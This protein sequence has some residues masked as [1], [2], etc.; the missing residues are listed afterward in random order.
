MNRPARP[1]SGRPAGSAAARTVSISEWQAYLTNRAHR[2]RDGRFFVQGLGPLARALANH[3]PL[4]TMLYRLG[5]PE[6]SGWARELLD[7]TEIPTVG[8]LPELIAELGDES[9]GA[10]E[11]VAVAR[12]RTE[13]LAAFEPA[14]AGPVILVVERLE[15]AEDL[16]TAIRNAA[17]LGACAV[18]V[19]GQA[20]DQ[21]D[22]RCV[23]ASAGTLFTLPV[24]R[25]SDPA[26]VL[27]FR[28]R[29]WRDGL[30]LR[31]VGIDSDGGTALFDHEFVDLAAAAELG[32]PP[33]R[34]GTVLVIGYGKGGMSAVWRRACD[35][36]LHVPVREFPASVGPIDP[37]SSAV[38]ALYEIARQ[39]LTAQ[40]N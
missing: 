10:P 14:G 2:N 3:W 8:L 38:A 1:S 21:F 27:A 39:Q 29:Q 33:V 7:N 11:I 18:I 12:A 16:G 24:F 5:S 28:D 6:L 30:L 35:A 15:S 26:A 40:Q 25:V 36:T 19:A 32:I 9:S 13:E 22:P 34:S 4:E 17:G 20:A 37:S 23:R 31:V